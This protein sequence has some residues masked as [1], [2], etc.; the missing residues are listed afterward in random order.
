MYILI[1]DVDNCVIFSNISSQATIERGSS[2][3]VNANKTEN[4][5]E[6]EVH[7]VSEED[8]RTIV[9]LLGEAVAQKLIELDE[10]IQA[11]EPLAANNR[12]V[13]F[14]PVTDRTKRGT[15]HKVRHRY[16]VLT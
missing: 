4:T 12:S 5:T 13:V 16:L 10:R 6:P 15:I 8:R 1:N 9:E 11:R 14:D 3:G 7:P 2:Q